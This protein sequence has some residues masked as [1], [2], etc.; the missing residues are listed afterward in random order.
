MQGAIAHDTMSELFTKPA[1]KANIFDE[2]SSEAPQNATEDAFPKPRHESQARFQWH[3][4]QQE[5][6]QDRQLQKRHEG[7]VQRIEKHRDI[8]EL[9]ERMAKA[10][11]DD[12][13]AE[14]QG[15]K[16]SVDDAAAK[17]HSLDRARKE[18]LYLLRKDV[19]HAKMVLLYLAEDKS[20]EID[21]VE[22][23]I[24]EAQARLEQI[25]N[26]QGQKQQSLEQRIAQVKQDKNDLSEEV[27]WSI[28]NAHKELQRSMTDK[29]RLEEERGTA[30]DAESAHVFEMEQH[31][32]Q[33]EQGYES[34]VR[35]QELKVID[36]LSE[37]KAQVIG[38]HFISDCKSGAAC[39]S[40]RS[41]V[42]PDSSITACA[43]YMH[44]LRCEADK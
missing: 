12:R 41:T 37:E 10:G 1:P 36:K 35:A 34:A 14:G 24:E 43:A 16:E 15:E 4:G 26:E 38:H 42:L 7:H 21:A 19:E 23:K 18:E 13:T 32:K 5:E 28:Q 39:G 30:M 20:R 9:Q 25:R 17:E 40:L 11:I 27:Q 8:Q 31:V 6:S 3:A 33:M 44:Y 22:Q 29:A 2:D